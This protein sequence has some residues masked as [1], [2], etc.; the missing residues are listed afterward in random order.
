MD[1]NFGDIA[2]TVDRAMKPEAL[3]F[4]H[5]GRIITWGETAARSNRLARAFLSKA[6]YGDKV[7]HYMRNGP[8]YMETTRACFKARLTH[9]NINYRYV[10]DEV[11]YIVE[12]SDAAVLVYDAAFRDIVR[13]IRPKLPLVTLY[14][15]IGGG[16]D[17]AE[18]AEDYEELATTGDGSPLGIRR[19]GDDMLFLYTG[20]TTGMP[21]G[22]MWPHKELRE[23]QLIGARKT[24]TA[25]ETLEE[26]AEAI[27]TN[28]PSPPYLPSEHGRCHRYAD[29]TFLRCA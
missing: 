1:W 16:A 22:V 7:A 13:E 26:I 18:F 9:V 24:G 21:K 23:V 12:N 17:R 20:G 28:G 15:E 19:S 10:P 6:K 2:D 11:A 4:A 25:H 27:I 14:V 8:A 29:Q 3:A 5:G